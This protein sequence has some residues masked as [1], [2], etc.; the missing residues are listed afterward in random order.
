[1]ILVTGA[2]G[3]IGRHLVAE[4][5][6]AGERVRAFAR[7]VLEPPPGV[8]LVRGDLS[9]PASLEPALDGVEAAFLLWP[10]ASAEG[11]AGTIE[12]LTERVPKI[13][14]LSSLTVRDDLEEQTH[15]MTAIH[16][17]IERSIRGAIS[18]WTFLRAGKFDTNALAWA[19]QIRETGSVRLPYPDAGR[20]PIH[21]R[22]VAAV[23]ARTLTDER[24]VGTSLVLTGP[25]A[26]TEGQ[27]VRATGAGLGREVGVEEIAPGVARREM[28]AAGLPTEL[29][30]A[31]LAYWEL[32]VREPE[33]V[34][35]TVPDITGS[36]GRMF[37]EW[38]RENAVRFA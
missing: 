3:N 24:F 25:E 26:L 19:S 38:M 13:V 9:V 22:D 36:P 10:Q 35:T 20:S 28:L 34:T 1:V 32:L 14:Y 31:A 33:P 7:G 12:V 16:A 4:L 21:E 27:I 29:A 2:T 23:A 18:R 6:A 15:P 30:D 5:A 37:G 8:E 11:H 17:D